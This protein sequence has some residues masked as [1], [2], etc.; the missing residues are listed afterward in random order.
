[1]LPERA[2]QKEFKSTKFYGGGGSPPP[3]AAPK[4]YDP[5]QEKDYIESLGY[6][7]TLKDSMAKNNV[8]LTPEQI[9]AALSNS[10][11]EIIA[12]QKAPNADIKTNWGN[13]S[14]F[15]NIAPNESSTTIIPQFAQQPTGSFSG[16]QSIDPNVLSNLQAMLS[17]SNY[18]PAVKGGK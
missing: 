14:R 5:T 16:V 12:Q 10:Q 13:L 1:M 2:F 7:N 3:A 15:S 18:L 9:I 6:L 11:R 4:P 8:Q 17:S